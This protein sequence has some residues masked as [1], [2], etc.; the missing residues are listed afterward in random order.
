MFHWKITLPL[1][2]AGKTLAQLCPQFLHVNVPQIIGTCKGFIA[3]RTIQ[4]IRSV[5]L[6]V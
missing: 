3:V 1:V 5:K 2:S 4:Y 6:T